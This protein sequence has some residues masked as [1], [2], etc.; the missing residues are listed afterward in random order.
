MTMLRRLFPAFLILA[1]L[2][3]A[4]HPPTQQQQSALL[5]HWELTKALRNQRETGVLAGITFDFGPDGQMLT[6]LP[7]TPEPTPS[8]YVVEKSDILQQLPQPIRYHILSLSDS[9]LV[10][11]M[12][13]QNIPFE[14]HLR[15]APKPAP[16]SPDTLSAPGDTST[17]H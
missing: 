14:L 11:T 15:R 16:V 13:M 1:L 10:L 12:E 9:T 3:P 7:V 4:C 5:G 8:P 2:F 6:T 17:L